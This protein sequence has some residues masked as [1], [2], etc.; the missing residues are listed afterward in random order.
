M[1]T[2]I[3]FVAF[4]VIITAAIKKVKR[5]GPS[6]SPCFTTITHTIVLITSSTVNFTLK[7]L[8]NTLN[9][10]TS[11]FGV[12]NLVS[13]I[14]NS[15]LGTRSK[16]STSSRKNTHDSKPCSLRFL[17]AVFMVILDIYATPTWT[18]PAL[19]FMI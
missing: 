4:H 17:M 9:K 14:H 8:C 15:S 5:I 18:K 6:M 19:W 7:S 16:A 3:L 1:Q 2:V 10:S 11:F 13:I 12:P